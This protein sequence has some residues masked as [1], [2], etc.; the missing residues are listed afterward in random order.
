[1]NDKILKIRELIKKKGIKNSFLAEKLNI[2]EKTISN[3]LTGR[4]KLDIYTIERIAEILEVPVGY[5]FSE[6]D[7]VAFPTLKEE[8]ILYHCKGKKLPLIHHGLFHSGSDTFASILAKIKQEEFYLLPDFSDA[9][10]VYKMHDSS[11]NPTYSP[12]DIIICKIILASLF[13][14]WGKTHIILTRQGGIVRRIFMAEDPYHIYCVADNKNF[15]PIFLPKKEIKD[16]A[17]VLGKI[18]TE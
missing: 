7:P 9:D 11:M 4:T 12:G 8:E 18:S 5:F 2:S 15:P 10:F 13:Y 17:M 6:A 1:M 3:Y 14:Q 16:I